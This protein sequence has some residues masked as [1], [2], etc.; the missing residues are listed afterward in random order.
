MVNNSF[1]P[2]LSSVLHFP[3]PSEN[4]TVQSKQKRKKGKTKAE[5]AIEAA[6]NQFIQYQTDTEE[7][8]RK[9]EEDRWMKEMEH[10]DQRRKE[11]R[12]HEVR[13]LRMLGDI[14]R[15]NYNPYPPYEEY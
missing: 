9:A 13:M 11:D 6:M 14:M 8:F 15:Q 3:L 5:K 7:R 2:P 10:E 4:S 12:E 1:F